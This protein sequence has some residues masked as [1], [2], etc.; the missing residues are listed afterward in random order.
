MTTVLKIGQRA[1]EAAELLPLL[2]GYQLLPQLLRELIIDQVIAS[3]ECSPEELAAATQQFYEQQQIVEV[4]PRQAWLNRYGMTPDQLNARASRSLKIEKYKQ[5]T[6]GH[7][8]ESYFIN[9]KAQLDRVIY[10]L[11]RTQDMG[12]AQELY[13]RIH[14]DAQSFADLARDYSQ[15]P[16][17]QTG[18]MLGPTELSVPHPILAKMLSVSQPGQLWPPTRLGEWIVV[19]RLEK[20]LPARLD[21]AMSQ[22]LLNELFET[23]IQ[24]QMSQA[25]AAAPAAPSPPNAAMP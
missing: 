16:E 5:A 19:V 12:I 24:D 17:A 22:R 6:W 11:I 4:A 9:R 2:A 3:I 15:G 14:D 21:A 20:F 13:F 1:V 7:K 18:G 8:L 25:Q 10:S 23:W